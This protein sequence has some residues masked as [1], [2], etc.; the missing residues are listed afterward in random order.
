MKTKLFTIAL[1]GLL[2]G[3]M[4]LPFVSEAEGAKK[5]NKGKEPPD[6]D[7]LFDFSEKKPGERWITVNDNVMGG[8]SKGGFS[9]K[10]DKLVFSGSTNTDGGGFSSIR[11]KPMDF[12][13]EDKDGFIIRFKGD[14]R[15][16]KCG[17]RME[18]SSASYRMDLETDKDAKGWQ[19]AK[20]PFSSMSASW[21][22]MRLPKERYPLKKD[23]IRSVTLMIYD[24]KDGPF[25]LQVDWIKAYSEEK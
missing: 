22:G 1:G 25:E 24:K 13:L 15:T 21:R 2:I 4:P 10:K 6:G 14:G 3:A 11:T 16:F 18:R 19:V 12:E 23:K 9:F 17:V 8:R 7:T 5:K 20:I